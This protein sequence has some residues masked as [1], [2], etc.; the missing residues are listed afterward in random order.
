ML[1]RSGRY[2]Y[3]LPETAWLP[4]DKFSRQFKVD[5]TLPEWALPQKKCATCQH[6]IQERTINR[7]HYTAE[8]LARRGRELYGVELCAPCQI[9]RARL[10]TQSQDQSPR[11]AAPHTATAAPSGENNQYP[12]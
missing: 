3:D 4:I 2:L 8:A 1:F 5:P 12:D 9:E 11:P 10:N 6:A 7:V